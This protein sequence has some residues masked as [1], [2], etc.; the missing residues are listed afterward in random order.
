MGEVLSQK[1]TPSAQAAMPDPL[2]CPLPPCLQFPFVPIAA[3]AAAGVAETAYLTIAK[4]TSTPVVCPISGGGCASVLTSD[5]AQLF[6]VLPLSAA[7]AAAYGAVAAL[8]VAGAAAARRGDERTEHALRTAVMAGGVLLATTS[9]YLMYIL[10]TAFPGEL[11][12]WCLGSAALSGGVATLALTAMQRRELEEAAAPASG[13]AAATLLCL[14][15]ALGTPGE[16]QAGT[17][18]TQLDYAQPV[19]TT[20]SPSGAAKLAER[21]RDAGARMYGAFWCSHCYEQKQAFGGDAMAAFPYVECFP[22]GWKAGIDMAP[23]C[24]EADIKGFP[25]W[26]IAGK[27]LEGEQTLEALE[28]VL[29]RTAAPA[30]QPTQ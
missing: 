30:A 25:T 15:L 26:V 18:I 9:A 2:A 14:S 29:D 22:E 24:S 1:V 17:G 6:G 13:L 12:P 5:Y 4:L 20:A 10:F 27:K 21:L 3:L 16:T 28:A 8:A 19:V 11:C 23:A 7:G